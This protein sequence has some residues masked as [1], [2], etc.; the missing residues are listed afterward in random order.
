MP[1]K[2]DSNASNEFR[3]KPD[4]WGP[5]WVATTAVLFLA[6]TGNFARLLATGDHATFKADYGLM[7]MS[8]TMI[9]GC[10][11][12]VPVITR[13]AL[14][15]SGQEADSINFKQMICVYGYSLTPTVPVSI[16]C[17]WPSELLRYMFCLVGL[18]FGLAFIKSHLWS[19]ISVEAP[20]LKWSMTG[21]LCG[22]Q[23]VIFLTYRLYFFTS[24]VTA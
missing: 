3:S 20:S 16:L 2:A 21:L 23:V 10:L 15:I 22:S 13:A 9:Y 1:F 12:A 4:F 19:D 14:W 24:H 18:A 7:S 8:A 11:V 17:L 6:A 5:F